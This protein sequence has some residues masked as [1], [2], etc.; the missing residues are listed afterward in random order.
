M[1]ARWREETTFDALDDLVA[2]LATLREERK[3][4]LTVSDGWQLFTPSRTLGEA[5]DER[6][7]A[8]GPPAPVW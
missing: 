7:S 3:A 4:I 1:K 6:S 8:F 5:D 2:H